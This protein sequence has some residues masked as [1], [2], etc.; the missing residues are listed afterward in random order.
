MTSKIFVSRKFPNYYFLRWND[1]YIYFTLHF[2]LFREY[3][4]LKGPI[5]DHLNYEHNRINQEET[6]STFH[7]SRIYRERDSRASR[8]RELYVPENNDRWFGWCV[9]EARRFV[10]K[11]QHPIVPFLTSVFGGSSSMRNPGSIVLRY[12]YSNN[13]LLEY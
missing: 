7:R 1:F 2:F 3:S 13:R 6:Q 11:G 9:W 5:S 4:T 8:D 12:V 10:T